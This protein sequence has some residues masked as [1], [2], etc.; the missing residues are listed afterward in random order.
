MK[1]HVELTLVERAKAIRATI[2]APTAA[3]T[4]TARAVIASALAVGIG[5]SGSAVA[6]AAPPPT[7]YPTSEVLATAAHPSLGKIPLRRGF[8]DADSGLGWGLDKAWNKYNIWS[9]EAQRRVMMS[10]NYTQK[11]D[12]RYSLVAYAGRYVCDNDTCK[13]TDRRKLIGVYN[14]HEFTTY[15]GWPVDGVL[16]LQNMYCE[17]GG[18][19]KCPDWVTYAILN[20]RVN[21]PHEASLDEAQSQG[22]SSTPGPAEEGL[23]PQQEA[24]QSSILHDQEIQSLQAEISAGTTQAQFSYQPLPETISAK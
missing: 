14:P 19:E 21:N 15:D 12:G 10:T 1:P 13:L 24:S 4:L 3:R 5:L 6:N 16:G 22:D 2:A 7:G 23:T 9:V 11:E 20:H 17:N 8:Y 18:K